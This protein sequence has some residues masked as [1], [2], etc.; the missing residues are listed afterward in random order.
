MGARIGIEEMAPELEQAQMVGRM[1]PP[2]PRPW[3]AS[4]AAAPFAY[5]SPLRHHHHRGLVRRAPPCR[6]RR[7][8]R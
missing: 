2:W 3:R 8:C 6:G 7:P 1:D 5:P 4:R